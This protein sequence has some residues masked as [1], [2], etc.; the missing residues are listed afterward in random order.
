MVSA[1][2]LIPGYGLRAEQPA[3][4]PGPV[5]GQPDVSV[6]SDEIQ[7][8]NE[9]LK[10]VW[11]LQQDKFL[12]VVFEDLRGGSKLTSLGEAFCVS[13]KSGGQI[14]ASELRV[15][16]K[17]GVATLKPDSAAA[18]LAAR[19][20]GKV[21]TVKL[22][23]SSGRLGV[24]WR[25]ILHDGANYLRQEVAF[26]ALKDDCEIS[27]IT[28][29]NATLPG[30][31]VRGAVD[32]SP[33][34]VGNFFLGYED[35]MAVNE[36]KSSVVAVGDWKPADV[37][38]GRRQ[39]RTW[40]VDP[41][42]LKPGKNELR[43]RYE[44]GAH[45]LDIWRVALLENGVE[46]AHDE[47]H[48]RT[49]S[50]QVGNVFSLAIPPVK[51]GVTYELIAEIGTDPDF[52]PAAGSPV[53]SFGKVE[54]LKTGGHVVCRLARH[55]TL[56]RGETLTQSFVV[57]VAPAG[58]MRRGFL[59]YLERE[60]AHPYRP[61]LHYNSWYDTA[62]DPFALNETN[63]MEAI[64]VC[65]ERFIKP[66]GVIMDG[67][68]FD[69]GWDNPKSL[70]QFHSGFPRGFTPLAEKCRQYKTRLGVWLSPF[71][72]YGPPKDQRLKFGREQGYEIN[73]AGLS[74]AGPKYY[75]AFKDACVGMIRNYGVNH[76]KFDG[77]A[78]GVYASGGGQYMLD[79]EAMRRLMLE[80]RQED[81]SVYINLTTGSWP[82]PFWLRYAD[83]LWRQG[84]DMGLAG[85]GSQQQQWLTYR[86]REVFRNVVGKGPLYPLNSLMTQGVAYSRFGTA[87]NQTFNS[88]GFKDDVRA[89]F[90]SGTGLQELYIQ[91]DKL[92]TDDWSVLAEAAKW[93]RANANVFVDT[94]WIGG[95]PAKLEVYGYA[96]WT[97]RKGI[98]MLRNP[99]DQ[100][101]ALDLDAGAV[102]E[103]PGGAARQFT[104][105]SPWAEDA[106]KPALSTQ[107][108][109]PLRLA[110][111]PFE[112]VI[113]EAKP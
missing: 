64:V 110:L 38:V 6:S 94:H 19:R 101:R 27:E 97:P 26:T 32:G 7:L 43:F 83:S 9:G 47:H 56:R 13:L 16:G 10:A 63:C 112:V 99:D 106:A 53:D 5:P 34:V 91:P 75:Q 80:L 98:V 35:P 77:I 22:E 82:S 108:G 78:H 57:G 105:H 81:A 60:R 24:V 71:G 84:Q 76:F 44:R 68:V 52:K 41:Q 49:G 17:P 40:P 111:K 11:T 51:R 66:H 33:V 48:G 95:D 86:D 20:A 96:S 36:V 90:G 87:G 4:F 58:Q 89:F 29:L 31:Q 25:G 2:C 59:H 79:T 102:F 70:W 85:K 107:A 39:V 67:M 37:L 28:F 103:L 74:L 30:A 65:G 15:I 93:S 42:S 1:L 54:W 50:E 46:V 12:P 92:T 113:L 109:Q 69:D 100:A 18:Q 62:Y 61:Y 55:A 23:D 73:D 72:G 8:G 21:V 104:L 14:K 45:R 3:I 88:A